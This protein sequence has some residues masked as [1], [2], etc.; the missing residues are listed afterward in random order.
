MHSRIG[1]DP[2]SRTA[3][4]TSIISLIGQLNDAEAGISALFML[5]G[6]STRPVRPE[7]LVAL[8]RLHLELLQRTVAAL[9]DAF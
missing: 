4:S 9:N 2:G 5:L 7:E 3:T 1:I 8:A 6:A